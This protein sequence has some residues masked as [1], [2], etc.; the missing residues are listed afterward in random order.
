MYVDSKLKT[1]PRMTA[2]ITT[3]VG[4][5]T[6]EPKFAGATHE[7]LVGERTRLAELQLKDDAP[8]ENVNE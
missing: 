4:L 2:A 5:V 3:G 6:A 1:T 7:M 8:T